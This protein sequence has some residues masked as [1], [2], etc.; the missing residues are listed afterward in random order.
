VA[1]DPPDLTRRE[2]DVLVALCQPILDQDVFSEPASVRAIAAELVVTEAAVKQH[3]LHLYDKFGIAADGSRRRLTLARE[4]IRLELVT[5]AGLATARRRAANREATL[6]AARAAHAARGWEA[7]YQGFAD[8]DEVEPLVVEDIEAAAEAAWWTNRHEQSMELKRRAYSIHT[9][10]H[11]TERAATTA[12]LLTINH[13]NRLELAV[14]DGWCSKARRLLDGRPETPVQGMLAFVECMFAEGAGD[15]PVVLERATALQGI[16]QRTG[17]ADLEALGVAFEGLALTQS[18]E[19]AAAGTRLLD[20]AMAS[21]LSGAIGP[22]AAG[23]IYCR[24]L[25]VCLA[26]HDYGR[27]GEWTDAILRQAGSSG[28]VGLPGDCH[29]HHAAVMIKRGAWAAG[30]EEAQAAADQAHTLDLSHVGIALCELAEIRLRQGDLASAETA[31]RRARE[32]GVLV[33]PGLALLRFARGEL[34]AART[35]LDKA[36]AANLSQPLVRARLLPALV[37]V[38]LA[39]GDAAA[40]G[41]AA[42]ELAE[43][44]AAFP[45]D[46]LRAAAEQAAGA[47]ELAAGT[48]DRAATRLESAR[49]LWLGVDA[50]YEVARTRTLLAETHGARGDHEARAL[51]LRAAYVTFEQLGARPDAAACAERLSVPP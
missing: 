37:E 28:F 13:A 26:A 18:A 48:P 7:A 46:A 47:V 51:E 19:T 31:I 43:T 29:T 40:A 23:V 32:Y 38:A 21:A 1:S 41:A 50:P 12:L 2:R 27:A 49:G 42:T 35:G 33:E 44:A 45:A 39:E 22:M 15:W 4:A 30:A 5:V 16:A 10:A 36:L 24:M 3:L 6:T 20:E 14:A 17:D 8:A 25:S 34:A 9:R 11:E